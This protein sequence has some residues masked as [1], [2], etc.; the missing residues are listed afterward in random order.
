MSVYIAGGPCAQESAGGIG[1]QAALEA[2]IRALC[3]PCPRP[4]V[5]PAPLPLPLQALCPPAWGGGPACAAT[6][7]DGTEAQLTDSGPAVRPRP[8]ARSV[9]P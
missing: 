6:S 5:P 1:K 7:S 4:P 8:L 2:V 9:S 3:P